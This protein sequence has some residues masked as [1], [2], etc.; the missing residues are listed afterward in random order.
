V[1]RGTAD[2]VPLYQEAVN[3]PGAH[4]PQ[5][6]LDLHVYSERSQERFVMINMHRLREGDS[7]GEGGRLEAITPEGALVSYGGS[8][9]LLTRE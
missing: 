5:L 9:F 4:L 2:G 8:R 1:Q 3:T 7:L 6:R